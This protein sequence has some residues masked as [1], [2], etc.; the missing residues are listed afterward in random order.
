MFKKRKRRQKKSLFIDSLAVLCFKGMGSYYWAVNY[1]KY[2]VSRI[3]A[4]FSTGHIDKKITY[5]KLDW[6]LTDGFQKRFSSI[7]KE[8]LQLSEI[9]QNSLIESLDPE[10]AHKYRVVQRYMNRLN[11]HGIAAYDISNCIYNNQMYARS[12]T[13]LWSNFKHLSLIRKDR[14]ERSQRAAEQAQSLFSN[15]NEYVTSFIAGVQFQQKSSVD[16]EDFTKKIQP[17]FTKLLT[18]KHSPLRNAD[19]D[20]NLNV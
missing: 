2:G 18:S 10:T 15:W 17:T 4:L 12:A 11:E 6:L 8:L 13:L 20:T 16:A 14:N 5:D 1:P 3:G 19:W 7:K 9:E